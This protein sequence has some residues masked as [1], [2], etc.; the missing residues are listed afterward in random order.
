MK[1]L[2]LI[3]INVQD[4]VDKMNS[5]NLRENELYSYQLRLEAIR[6]YCSNAIEKHSEKRAVNKQS[7]RTS[8]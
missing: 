1:N 7:M 3:P 2:H 8:H 5:P 4:I 6:D